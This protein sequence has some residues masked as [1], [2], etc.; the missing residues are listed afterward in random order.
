MFR[1]GADRA[2]GLWLLLVLLKTQLMPLAGVALLVWRRPRAIVAFALGAGGL[3]GA[4]LLGFGN[5]L[6]GLNP[7]IQTW[8][9]IETRERYTVAMPTW[10]GLL[11]VLLGTNASL[12]AQGIEAV[13]VGV[14]LAGAGLLCWPSGRWGQAPPQVRFAVAAILLLL[15]SPHLYIHD[16]VVLLL[17][18][19]LF[20]QASSAALAARA[21][22][23]VHALRWVL[24]LGPLVF[25]AMQFWHPPVAQIGAWYLVLLVA[26]ALAA[27]LIGRRPPRSEAAAPVPGA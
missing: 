3:L 27:R 16:L 10:R 25:Y 17:P 5:W 26:V 9:D 2:A 1:R 6:A 21:D 22:A 19:F 13:L 24:G 8:L 18:G 11:N 14:S 12:P 20:W 15:A 4:S 23:R 7:L